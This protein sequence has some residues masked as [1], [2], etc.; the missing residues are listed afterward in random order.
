MNQRTQLAV[1]SLLMCTRDLNPLVVRQLRLYLWSVSQHIRNQEYVCT[2]NIFLC[3]AFLP[4]SRHSCSLSACSSRPNWIILS[5]AAWFPPQS[6]L[7]LVQPS[8]SGNRH[9]RARTVKVHTTWQ[10]MP[11]KQEARCAKK[12]VKM[13]QIRERIDKQN[14]KKAAHMLPKGACRV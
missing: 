5:V 6:C 1:Q 13:N 7:P 14:S 11:K 4:Y 12:Q 3:V 8:S 10:E 9:T 2:C